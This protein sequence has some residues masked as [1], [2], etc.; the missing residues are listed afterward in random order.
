MPVVRK[1][2]EDTEQQDILTTEEAARYLR[3]SSRT[4]RQLAGSGAI[5]ARKVGREW[6]FSRTAIQDWVSVVPDQIPRRTAAEPH[7]HDR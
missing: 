6:R 7:D 2:K 4:L 5:P 1:I 3:V